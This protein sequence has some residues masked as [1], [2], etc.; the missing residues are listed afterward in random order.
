MVKKAV[1]LITDDLKTI[2]YYNDV[3]LDDLET[4]DFNNDTQMNDLTCI[5]KI[6]LKKSSAMQKAA[7][8]HR[9]LKRKG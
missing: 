3:T 6:D 2:D 5:D 1:F 9:N 8:K 4:I 7:K